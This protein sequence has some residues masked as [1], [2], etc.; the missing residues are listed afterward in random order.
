[1]GRSIVAESHIMTGNAADHAAAPRTVTVTIS[2]EA[3]AIERGL[4]AAGQPGRAAREK[5]YLKSDLEFGGTPAAGIRSVA[6]AWSRAHPALAH[7]ELLNV[8]AALWARP[9][10]ECRAA[11]VELLRDRLALLRAADAAQIEAMLR[12]SYTWALVDDLAEKVM[13]GLTE[14]FP[15]LTG[16][17]DRWARDGDFWVRRSA[18]LALLG[19]LR[20]GGGDFERFGRYADAMLAEREFFIRKAIGWVLRDTARRRPELVAAWLAPRVHLVSGITLREAVKPLEAGTRE[21]LMAGYRGK[22]PVT[23][24]SPH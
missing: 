3:A 6:K 22:Y 1:M 8:T 18:L 20:R 11:A 4:R 14:A 19:P 5:A 2:A 23:L 7:G 21:M 17:L 24:A 12:T 10:F 16:T 13:G 15:Q 9:V